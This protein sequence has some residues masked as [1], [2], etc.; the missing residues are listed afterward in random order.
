MPTLRKSKGNRWMARVIMDGKQVACKMFPAGKKYGPEWRA[1]KQ[2]EEEQRK[3]LKASAYNFQKQKIAYKKTE[4]LL[5][6]EEK[7]RQKAQTQIDLEKLFSWGD[8]YLE[9][10]KRTVTHQTYVGKQLVMR[11]FFAFCNKQKIL[12][13][14][15]ITTAK[16]Y[17]FLSKINDTRGGHVANMYRRNMLAAWTWGMDFVEDFPQ[18]R[19]PIQKIKNFIVEKKDRYVPS[20]E[21]IVKVFDVAKGQD[22]VILFMLYFTGA[23]KGEVFRLMWDDIDL[24]NQTIRLK[25]NKAGNGQGRVRWIHMHPN[26]VQALMWWEKVR[27]CKVN[28]VFM[29]THSKSC[30]GD[31][32]KHRKHFMKRL[33]SKAGVQ[34]FGFHAIRHKAAAV[35]FM[36]SGLNAAQTLM[37]HYRATT[38]DIYTKSAGLYS[39]QSDILCALGSSEIGQETSRLLKNNVIFGE[40]R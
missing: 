14:E 3:A 32:F 24:T 39:D 30:M 4:M 16:C 17:T 26:L 1:A 22:L 19:S 13:V 35:T 29:Q 28:N 33:C 18:I 5:Q 15:D 10:A 38:T 21:D 6:E 27:P 25:D 34:P 7:A 20:D 2:W 9:H 11:D 8:T 31:A 37:G 12:S 40:G 36:E 23:R